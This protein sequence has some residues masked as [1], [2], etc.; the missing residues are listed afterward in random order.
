MSSDVLARAFAFDKKAYELVKKGHLLRAAENFGRGAEAAHVLGAD[1]LVALNMQLQQS[2]LLFCYATTP[3]VAIDLGI[4][5]AHAAESIALLSEAV[6]ALER[7]RVTGMLLE[8]KCA[9]VE[10]AWNASHL[11]QLEEDDVDDD[12]DAD[13]GVL[14]SEAASWAPLVGYKQFLNAA[15]N[16]MNVLLNAGPLA[17]VCSNSQL[18]AYAKHVVRAAE[19]IQQPRCNGDLGLRLEACFTTALRKLVAQADGNGL[20]AHLAQLLAGAQQRLEGSGVLQVRRVEER[21]QTFNR[22]QEAVTAAALK[23]MTAPGLRSCA[24]PGCGA[25][26]AHPAHFKSCAAC[27]VVVYCCREHQVA[28]WPGHKKACKAARKAAAAAADDEAGPSGA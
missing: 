7:R 13:D 22:K 14:A 10:E 5:L 25:R 2:N 26:E 17:A 21:L 23:S 28:G 3:N 27:R 18:E 8:G 11:L 9:A 19:L 15:I 24:L 4:R 1:N 6:A 12:D 16:A 20:D